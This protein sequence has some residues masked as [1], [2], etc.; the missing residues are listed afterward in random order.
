MQAQKLEQIQTLFRKPMET[1]QREM[2]AVVS[3]PDP[4][5]ERQIQEAIA[6]VLARNT[7]QAAKGLG[8]ILAELMEA[9]AA[10][11]L[12]LTDS[13]EKKARLLEILSKHLHSQIFE[14]SE[15]LTSDLH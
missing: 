13:Q 7:P 5:D 3:T 11:V 14:I 2:S 9:T 8:A 6:A 15:I 4:E 10:R 12:S 1:F